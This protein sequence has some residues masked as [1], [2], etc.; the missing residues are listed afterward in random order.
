[1]FYELTQVNKKARR[2]DININKQK[3]FWDNPEG[4][5]LVV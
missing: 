1:M 4:V 2:A 5:A 3:M